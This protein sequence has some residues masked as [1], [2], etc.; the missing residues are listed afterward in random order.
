MRSWRRHTSLTFSEKTLGMDENVCEKDGKAR[1]L[2]YKVAN[3]SIEHPG[4]GVKR[5][6]IEFDDYK[7]RA[8]YLD[9]WL[10]IAITTGIEELS[11]S[12]SMCQK[13][14]KFPWSLL[15]EGSGNSIRYLDLSWCAFRPTVRLGLR[16][17]TQLTLFDVHI[18]ESELACLLDNSFSLQQL[19]LMWCS[20][21]VR[22]KIP[23]LVQQLI[24]LEVLGY[25]HSRG[26]V[27]DA[28]ANLPSSLPNLE[29]LSVYSYCE[30]VST[31]MVGSK[32][33]FLK[34]LTVKLAAA[35]APDYDYCS[36]ISFFDA[37][38][39]L[40]TFFLNAFLGSMH[41][42]SIL[43][44]PSGRRQMPEHRYDKLKNVT[45]VGFSSAKTLVELTC[46]ILDSSKSLEFLTLDATQGY[47]YLRCS[48]NRSGKCFP[49]SRDVILEGRRGLL[50]IKKCIKGI[51]PPKVKFTI[52]EPCS[53]CHVVEL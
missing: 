11:V 37:S 43:G 13:R 41:H 12:S 1:D 14:F 10:Q 44:D 16:S 50:A 22:L 42:P 26:A 47:D 27:C 51:V 19:T 34:H 46:H 32:F 48:V 40:E 30:V 38:P 49:V 45:I 23:P 7:T 24:T 3:I 15:S 8:Y 29:T 17:L 35:A 52:V 18:S 9:R 31:P 53:Q 28:R 33:P 36:L 4:I 5:V 25:M 21:I 2:T 20:K 39:S 6:R